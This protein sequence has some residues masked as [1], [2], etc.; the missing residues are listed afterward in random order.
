MVRLFGLGGQHPDS[1]T[2][3]LTLTQKTAAAANHY[4]DGSR[5]LRLLN[6]DRAGHVLG[7]VVEQT[8]VRVRPGLR[9]RQTETLTGK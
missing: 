2:N 6:D 8:V 5:F 4:R 3:F 1:S 7:V 9:Q